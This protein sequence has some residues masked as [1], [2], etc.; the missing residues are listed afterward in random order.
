MASLVV[1]TIVTLAN[2]GDTLFTGQLELSLAWIVPLNYVVA[3]VL[4]LTS[5]GWMDWGGK[6]PLG[7]DA[8]FTHG[9]EKLGGR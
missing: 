1:G 3:L 5:G 8:H 2:H 7:S 9:E 4:V 6:T